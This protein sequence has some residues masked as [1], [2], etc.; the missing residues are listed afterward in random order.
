[1]A[2]FRHQ[3]L[4]VALFPALLPF[5]SVFPV[6]LHVPIS[7]IPASYFGSQIRC[8]RSGTPWSNTMAPEWRHLVRSRAAQE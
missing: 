1:M 8:S 5:A 4:F 2:R 7:T 3:L 6:N